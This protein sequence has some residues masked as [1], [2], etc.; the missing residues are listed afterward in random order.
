MTSASF[1]TSVWTVR[2]AAPTASAGRSI[3]CIERNADVAAYLR[4]ALR[5]AG[6]DVHTSSN[7]RD[8]LLLMRVT[9]FDLLLVGTDVPGSPAVEKSFHDASAKMPM[10]NLGPEFSTLEA[11]AATKELL[12]KIAA[13]LQP[14]SRG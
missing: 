9:R 3:L 2:Q 5:N 7:L 12:E 8:S 1:D 4:E 13:K 10:I 14:G 11:G 6:Y